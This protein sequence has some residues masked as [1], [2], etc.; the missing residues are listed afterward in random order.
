[1]VIMKFLLED[2][3]FEKCQELSVA[4]PNQ[5]SFKVTII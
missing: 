3:D 5:V 2:Q 1:M 4:E